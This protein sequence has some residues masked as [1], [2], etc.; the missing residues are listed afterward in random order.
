[1]TTT[2]QLNA[3]PNSGYSFSSW[4][5]TGSDISLSATN[6]N[7]TTLTGGGS[8]ASSQ[9][10]TANFSANNYTITLDDKHGG[11]TS[12]SVTYDATSLTSISHASFEGWNLL[13]Y[14]NTD[15][16]K[17]IEANGDIVANVV[18]YTGSSGEWNYAN[19]VTL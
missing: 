13:G 7:P 17:V 1:M 18:N 10:V 15:G 8:G 19:N 14:W 3:V 9:S 2:R 11:T 4:S 6:T 16:N 12:A 5:I